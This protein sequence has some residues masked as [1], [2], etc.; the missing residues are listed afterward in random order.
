MSENIVNDE[1]P[2]ANEVVIP[3]MLQPGEPIISA[4]MAEKY[5]VAVE[6]QKAKIENVKLE[7]AKEEKDDNVITSPKADKEDKPS[8]PALKPVGDGVMGSSSADKKDKVAPASK[9]DD[10]EKVAVFS[11]KNV[12]WLGVGKVST[13]YNIVTKAQAEQWLKRK[14][15]RL[16]TPEEVA[17]E[18]KK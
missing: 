15:I 14:H 4:D 18:F 11:T 17:K 7:E 6:E 3:A 9:E 2:E 16:A 8:K 12:S 10:E 13:G 5:A 1:A